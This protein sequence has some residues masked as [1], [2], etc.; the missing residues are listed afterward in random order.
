VRVLFDAR[1]GAACATGIGRYARTLASVLREPVPGHDA[2]TLG[3]RGHVSL[4]ARSP[5]EEELELPGLLAEEEIDLFHSPLFHLPAL[6]PARSVVT[7]HDAIPA[8]RP[9]LTDT[10]FARLFETAAENTRRANRVVCPTEHARRDVARALGLAASKIHVVPEAPAE[11]FR[12]LSPEESRPVRERFR[13]ETPFFLVM[14][15]V[16]KRKN[17]S[18]VLDALSCLRDPPVVVFAGPAAGYPLAEEAA[19]RGLAS[20]VRELGLV[21][22]E[23]LVALLNEATALVFPSLYEG[24]GLPVVEAFACGTPVIASNA[25]SIPEVAGDA[26]LLFD[27]GEP[28]ALTDHL[29]ALLGSPELRDELRAKGRARLALFTPARVREALARLYDEIEA[30]P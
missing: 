2:W 29:R 15:S 13:L 17:P 25:A 24:F 12:P 18:V 30:S 27:P 28:A 7:I 3:P 9:D 5:L 6:L 21:S 16:E 19:K 23:D 1:P 8:V 4:A 26:G 22:D 11:V 10:G 20:R 14:G